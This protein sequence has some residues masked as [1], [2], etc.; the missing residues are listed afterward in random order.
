MVGIETA[1]TRIESFLTKKLQEVIAMLDNPK[2]P[3]KLAIARKGLACHWGAQV[4]LTI[5]KTVLSS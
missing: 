3:G 1:D 4:T 5:H 2:D